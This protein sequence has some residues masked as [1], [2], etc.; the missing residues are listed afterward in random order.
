MTKF[1]EAV[2]DIHKALK[3]AEVKTAYYIQ[4][5]DKKYASALNKTI[6]VRR[7]IA[8]AALGTLAKSSGKDLKVSVWGGKGHR[9]PST[10][11]YDLPQGYTL[12]K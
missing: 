3:Q 2:L 5:P 12:V 8:E 7:D 6:Y 9:F 1:E 4:D 10:T 11:S